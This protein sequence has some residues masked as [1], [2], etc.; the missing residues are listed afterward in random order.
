M[1][2]AGHHLYGLKYA[3]GTEQSIPLRGGENIDRATFGRQNCA[4]TCYTAIFNLACSSDQYSMSKRSASLIGVK[5][6]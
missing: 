6:P 2:F 1:G 3:V 4:A 5:Q